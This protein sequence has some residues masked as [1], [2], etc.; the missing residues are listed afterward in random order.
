M[1][2]FGE[3]MR[4]LL[5]FGILLAAFGWGLARWWKASD[6]R[7]ALLFR[8]SLT[9]L[10]LGFLMFVA[11]PLVL[12]GGYTG[13]FGGIPMTAVAGLVL[14]IIW[15]R[16]LAESVGRKFGQLYDGGDVAPEPMPLYSIAEARRKQGR[17]AEAVAEVRKQLELFPE[18]LRLHLLL[19]E[20][21]ADD[22]HDLEAA[23]VTVERLVNQPGHV[24]KNIAFALTWLGDRLLRHQKDVA[25]ARECFER[26]VALFPDSA[27]AHA[28]HQRMA[29]L[30]TTEVLFGA[31]PRAAIVVPKADPQLGLRTEYRPWQPTPEDPVAKAAALVAQLEKFPMDNQARED[32]AQVYAVELGRLDL[33]VEQ[34]EQLI[35]QPHAADKLVVHWLNLV[36]DLQ[37]KVGG[38]ASRGRAA[39]A[40][41]GERFPGSASAETAL[42][43]MSTLQLE[44]RAK[45]ASQVIPLGSSRKPSADEAL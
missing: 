17:Y 13:A 40:R 9:A 20:I 15:T 23:R 8:W 3:L 19:A 36:A 37:V 26:I 27:E 32:L 11:V 42:R 35:E 10:D 12:Q 2:G 44:T 28:A 18:D 7:T 39:L 31:A 22:L 14:A 16:P 6:D 5:F 21:Q 29:R 41:I 24:P 1:D 43:R 30:G 45:K 25:G 33:A 34:L 4:A 38:D